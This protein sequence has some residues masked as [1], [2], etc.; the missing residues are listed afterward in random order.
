MTPKATKTKAKSKKAQAKSSRKSGAKKSA[1]KK[2]TSKSTSRK[3]A[4]KVTTKAK[5]TGKAA[6]KSTRK[7][8]AKTSSKT[9]T[10]REDSTIAAAKAAT[11]PR[12]IG[13]KASAPSDNQPQEH[14]AKLDDS[15]KYIY[16]FGGGKADG[17]GSMR[18]LL[19]GKGAGLAEMTNLGV[20]VPPG[21][22]I[23]TE[24]CR[25]FYDNNLAL[26]KEFEK[27][28][29]AAMKQLEKEMGSKFGDAEDPLLVSV[30]SGAKFSMPGMMDTILNLGL[31]DESLQGIINKTGNERFAYDNYRRFIA[32]FGN[33][34]LGI[35]K[36][37]FEE[38]ITKKKKQRAIKH[39]SSLS[40]E[41]LKDIVKNFKKLVQ[42]KSGEPFPTDPWDQLR[43]ARDA[44]FRSWNSPRAITYRAKY[45]IPSDLGTAV[46]VQAMVFGNMGETSATG[47]GFTRNPATGANEFYG[48]F[49]INAQGEDVVAGIRTPQPIKELEKEMP[50]AFDQLKK[51]TAKLEHHYRD[52][53]DFEFTIQENKLYMLQ[54]RTGK[55]TAQAAVKIAVDM[56]KEGLITK[57]EALM[58]LEPSDLDQLL[59]PR[60]DP[61]A[62]TETIARGLAASPGAA[63]G[64]V[65]FHAD[66]AVRLNERGEKT[67]LVRMETNPD[68]IA[69]MI[70]SEGILT[71]RGGM[72]S[73]AAVVAR[74]MGKPCVVGCED[75]RVYE[76]RRQF[77]IGTLVVKDKEIITINGTTG[78]VML[79]EVP[80]LEPELSGEF[81]EFM[82]WADELRVL[83][84]RTNADNPEDSTTARRFGAQGIGLCRTEHMFFGKNR[85]PHIQAMIL[86]TTQSDRQTALDKLLPFQKSDFKAIFEAMEG[87]PVTI[88]TLDPPLHEFL[89]NEEE[90]KQKLA[91]ISDDPDKYEEVEKIKKMLERME[92]LEEQNPMLGHRGCR[93]GITYPEIT[94]MQVKAIMMAAADLIK[95]GKEVYPEIMIP[96]VGNKNELAH[97]KEVVMRVAEFVSRK[98]KVEIPFLVGT[99]IE[100]PRAALTA[101]EIA[102][103]AQFFSFGTNDLTQMTMG[104]SRDDAGKFL[105]HYYE[106][107]ILEKDPFV[108][109]D[110]EGVGQ[111]VKMGAEKGRATRP[112]LKVGICGEHGGDPKTIE[113]CHK[114]GLNYVSCSPFRVPIA[115]LAAAQAVIR[116][117]WEA[118]DR[119]KP[120]GKPSKSSGKSSSKSRSSKAAAKPKK[121]AKAATAKKSAPKKKAKK[122]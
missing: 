37:E 88:R 52:V 75:I 102:N 49:L 40:I 31:N 116:E 3:T 89:P 71:S 45:E 73:H 99:M 101:D 95:Q 53:Q 72:T 85:L 112:D 13:V 46:N 115:R 60:I 63:S 16:S 107:E 62:E 84:V 83:Q 4:K 56:V 10:S 48:E 108:T 27:H 69:G 114:L 79:G 29:Q 90:L 87:L 103:E 39:D 12:R 104:F 44:V 82:E 111:L 121:A 5:S 55:R 65:V 119:E 77:A 6:G 110:Q 57:E 74:G 78:E 30:R 11:R 22:T 47:V 109:L 36:D 80:T 96:L 64:K 19:G 8:S 15:T 25:L 70:A 26:P 33:V 97:Q 51:I 21:F 14:R 23:S 24:A 1:A 106:K 28:M 122:K 120:S 94:E 68:D 67:I 92:E 118:G 105:R 17:E 91:E 59:H 41:D 38:L 117:K 93:L 66:E 86:A 61:D 32:M 54:T 9:K 18:E 76:S 35:D 113:F 100:I 50:K 34:V 7:A 2:P 42:K 43:M 81:G 58:R 98:S 20:P